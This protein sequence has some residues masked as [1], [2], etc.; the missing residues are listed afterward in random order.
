M[1]VAIVGSGPSACF[2]VEALLERGDPIEIDV[3]ERLPSLFGLVRF[4]VAPD[5]PRT[6]RVAETFARILSADR[7]KVFTNV[8]VGR[9]VSIADLRHRY[10]AVVL[11]TGA[12]QDTKLAIP[13][14]DATGIFGAA[15]FVGWYN[16]HPDFAA[17]APA[18]DTPAMAVVGMGNVALD[19][20]R[21]LAKTHEE[22]RETEISPWAL[23]A[24]SRSG[25]RDIYIIGRRG[26]LDAKFTNP[27]LREL[28]QLRDAV[29]IVH[30]VCLPRPESPTVSRLQMRNLKTFWSFANAT[31]KG[32]HKRVHFLFHAKPVGIL[33]DGRVSGVRLDIGGS[34]ARTIDLAC[35]AVITA[36]GFRPAPLAGVPFDCASGLVVH[37]NGR[38]DRGLY[39]VGWIK[40]GPSGVIGTSK[41]DGAAA[42]RCI[43]EDVVVSGDKDGR[44]WLDAVLRARGRQRIG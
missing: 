8:E 17:L 15:Q 36:I 31:R 43:A 13:G 44:L 26:A 3:L 33:G 11:A 25:I 16:G 27:E 28:D 7:V 18:L 34:A 32:A 35:G 23:D 12:T 6:R 41:P 9:E 21:L 22:L 24:I 37:D 30:G 40:R 42:A 39:A 19:V 20:A 4:G 10:D 29:P 14:A 1:R 38:I 5:H 2:T